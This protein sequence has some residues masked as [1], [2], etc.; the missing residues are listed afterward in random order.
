MMNSK[1]STGQSSTISAKYIYTFFLLNLLFSFCYTLFKGKFNGDFLG[2]I[3]VLPN[4]ILFIN[5]L[6]SFLPFYFLWKIYKYFKAKEFGK[7][8]KLNLK[9]FG[10]LTFGFLL[11]HIFL[12]I[13]YGV[14]VMAAPAY[15]APPK[16]KFFIQIVNRFSCIYAVLLYFLASNKKDRLQW[17]LLFLLLILSYLRAGLG[18]LLYIFMFAII[19]YSD[20]VIQIVKRRKL[21]LIALISLSPPLISLL[22]KIRSFLRNAEIEDLSGIEL[23]VG[24]VSGRLSSFSDSGFILQEIPY[25][26]LNAQYMDPLYFQKQMLSGV[27][28]MNFLPEIRPEKLLFNYYYENSMD[29]VAYMAGTQGNLI[30][31]L[32]KSPVVLLINLL[33]IFI[34]CILTFKIARLLRFRYSNEFAFLLLIYIMLSGVA[35][36]LAFV[37]F[38]VFLFFFIFLIL[39]L[40]SINRK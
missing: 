6:L 30:I 13:T 31:S 26:L 5:L 16:V 11:I 35:N 34:S 7:T 18:V 4:W 25:F 2:V 19:K 3:I 15:Q 17:V 1:P 10:L 27:I 40:F 24:R 20:I 32:F 14:G 36:E 12:T 33:T 28:S 37:L 23:I 38:S 21:G 22:F 29:N 39:R 9:L 8:I